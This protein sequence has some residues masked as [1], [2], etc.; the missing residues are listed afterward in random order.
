MQSRNAISTCSSD[1]SH[2]QQY[3]PPPP[4]L[5]YWSGSVRD[6][7]RLICIV[8]AALYGAII[9]ITY[10]EYC[11]LSAIPNLPSPLTIC[12]SIFISNISQVGMLAVFICTC[13][14]LIRRCE[15]VNLILEQLLSDG[16]LSDAYEFVNNSQTF[17]ADLKYM[18]RNGHGQRGTLLPTT[19]DGGPFD[20]FK[21]QHRQMTPSQYQ[22]DDKLN[23]TSVALP[24]PR[25]RHIAWI[26]PSSRIA[27]VNTNRLNAWHDSV[28]ETTMWDPEIDKLV[29][30]LPLSKIHLLGRM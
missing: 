13:Q 12:A 30:E 1:L 26:T 5:F 24:R 23:W 4:H 25:S 2:I 19:V 22:T 3:F 9:L 16:P 6:G 20:V 28:H 10:I 27:N 17:V 7:C 8:L 21:G 18:N 14:Y 11:S 15:C 29:S